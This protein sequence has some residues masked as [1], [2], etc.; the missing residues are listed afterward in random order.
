MGE[1]EKTAK[2]E[3]QIN[4]FIGKFAMSVMGAAVIAVAGWCYSIS[5]D[6]AIMKATQLKRE[7]V[8]EAVREALQP[9]V[10]QV[11]D[12][13]SRIRIMEHKP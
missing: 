5:T 12:H 8:K 6:V 10:G 11:A 4:A 2:S 1:T 7:E 3:N 9:L 13:E